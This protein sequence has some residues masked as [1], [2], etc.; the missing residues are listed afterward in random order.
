MSIPHTQRMLSLSKTRHFQFA[1][2][3]IAIS[4]INSRGIILTRTVLPVQYGGNTICRFNI[5]NTKAHYWTSLR[6]VLILNFIVFFFVPSGYFPI[7]VCV[8]ILY[9]FLTSP[10]LATFTEH[11]NFRRLCDY[12]LLNAQWRPAYK[13]LFHSLGLGVGLTTLHCKMSCVT[14]YLYKPTEFEGLLGMT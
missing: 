14:K 10:F 11:S 6:Y 8:K 5:S 9:A 7:D 4:R 12:N 1:I 3:F 2:I 13:D